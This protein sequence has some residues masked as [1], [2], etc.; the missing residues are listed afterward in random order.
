MQRPA[1][2]LIPRALAAVAG[3]VM[4]GALVLMASRPSPAQAPPR[5]VE[6]LRQVA[7]ARFPGTRSYSIVRWGSQNF[8]LTTTRH[9]ETS[10]T[11]ELIDG[12]WSYIFSYSASDGNE[13]I[14][15]LYAQH[16]FSTSMRR[17]MESDL[18][19]FP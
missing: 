1:S 10:A 8:A 18:R 6:G 11:W 9:R 3:I 7:C 5:M 15:Q 2:V 17:R 14:N 12:H 19:R 16:Q 4:L 13:R